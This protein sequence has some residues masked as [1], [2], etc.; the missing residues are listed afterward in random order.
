MKTEPL[1]SPKSWAKPIPKVTLGFGSARSPCWLRKSQR[2]LSRWRLGNR[3]RNKFQRWQVDSSARPA[4][5]DLETVHEGSRYNLIFL[6]AV[7]VSPPPT[8]ALEGLD[9]SYPVCPSSLVAGDP[10]R[11][12]VASL[13]GDEFI[14]GD[15]FVIS[16][17]TTD[18]IS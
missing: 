10:V 5:V 1:A 7:M 12:G 11:S 3:Q 2:K 18:T 14:S 4:P 9:S 16:S 15:A 17:V 13:D 8:P 6:G